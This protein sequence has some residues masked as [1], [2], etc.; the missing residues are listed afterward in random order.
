MP[1]DIL[2]NENYDLSLENG[3]F[4][5]GESTTQHQE[6]ILVADEGEFRQ[7]PFAGVG[8]RKWSNDDDLGDLGVEIKRKFEA[9]GQVVEESNVFIEDG[10][11]VPRVK[12]EYN[13]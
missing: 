11:I 10:K 12:A 5:P 2:L 3:D 4:V 8:I 7:Y 13:D 6:H 9:D 1:K